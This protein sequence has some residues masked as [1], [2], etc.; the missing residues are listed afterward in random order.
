MFVD[1]WYLD[2]IQRQLTLRSYYSRSQH[3]FASPVASTDRV[4]LLLSYQVVQKWWG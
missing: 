4:N 1:L 2:S 3:V